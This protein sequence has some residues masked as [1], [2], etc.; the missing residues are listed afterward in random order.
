[1]CL[2]LNAVNTSTHIEQCVIVSNTTKSGRWNYF[3]SVL[4][5]IKVITYV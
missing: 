3:K 2:A 4:L 1:M 5:A